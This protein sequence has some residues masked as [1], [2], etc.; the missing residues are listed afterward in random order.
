MTEYPGQGV[1]TC[2]DCGAAYTADGAFCP[3]CGRPRSVTQAPVWLAPAGPAETVTEAE[4][5]PA[6]SEATPPPFSAGHVQPQG[7]GAS[8]AFGLPQDSALPQGD[9]SVPGSPAGYGY[10]PARRYPGE[11]G[12]PPAPVRRG[13]RPLVVALSLM[14]LVAA[15][16]FG[17]LA[18]NSVGDTHPS[19][20]RMPADTG[21]PLASGI[22]VPSA[23][24]PSDIPSDGRTLGNP[25]ATVTVDEWEDY[26]C[27]PCGYW[28]HDIMPKLITA[29]VK[30]GKVKVAVHYV[31]VIDV[32]MGGHESADAANAALCASDQGMFWVYQDWLLANQ[33]AEA[34]G[35]FSGVR[36]LEMGRRAGLDMARF[37]P[38]VEAGT[39][40]AEVQAEA[41]SALA[42][43]INDAPSVLVNGVEVT[44]SLDYA[45][46]AAAIDSV[47]P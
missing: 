19:P 46:I 41:A 47:A 43:S 39:H 1:G 29:Y 24:T 11:Y 42:A 14:G 28:A 21:S 31:I 37:R 7:F 45:T 30:P 38:C 17:A 23:F 27:P 32:T 4:Y 35:A 18:V 34:S 16:V 20:S 26:Q 25:S 2:P 15:L 9:G 36:L 44:D 12:Y 33:G 6:P 5:T 3:G 8:E 40:V 22:F 13:A 10:P